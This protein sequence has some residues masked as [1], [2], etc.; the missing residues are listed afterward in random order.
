[1][2][3]YAIKTNLKNPNYNY[4][5]FKSDLTTAFYCLRDCINSE[6]YNE[7]IFA[8][9]G[10]PVLHYVKATNTLFAYSKRGAWYLKRYEN[11]LK[12]HGTTKQIIFSALS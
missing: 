7:L 10:L 12:T 3:K 4:A 11:Y 2:K 1:M 8:V 6:F 5:I 9:D